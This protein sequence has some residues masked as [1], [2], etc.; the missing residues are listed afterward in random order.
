V[1]GDEVSSS[2]NDFRSNRTFLSP[3]V[4][5]ILERGSRDFSQIIEIEVDEEELTFA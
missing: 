3:Q 1:N 2:M 4:R 5:R